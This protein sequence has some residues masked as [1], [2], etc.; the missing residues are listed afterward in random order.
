MLS[1]QLLPDLEK[2]GGLGVEMSSTHTYTHAHDGYIPEASV[3]MLAL[4]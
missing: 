1:M 4:F 3:S 2:K